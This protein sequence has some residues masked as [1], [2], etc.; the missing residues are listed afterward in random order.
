MT[1]K[2]RKNAANKLYLEDF[3]LYFTL[4]MITYIGYNVNKYTP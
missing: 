1:V 2:I 3:E 4:P